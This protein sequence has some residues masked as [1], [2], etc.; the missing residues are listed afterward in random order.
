MIRSGLRGRCPN[1]SAMDVRSTGSK[2]PFCHSRRRSPSKSAFGFAMRLRRCFAVAALP[3]RPRMDANESGYRA[4]VALPADDPDRATLAGL[5]ADLARQALGKEVELDLQAVD[6]SGHWA[7]VRARLLDPGGAALSLGDTPFADAA[8]A[9]GVSDLAV[10]LFRLD[11]KST[12][13]N[14]S[15]VAIS[16]AVFCLKQ[17]SA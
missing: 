15:H 2:P 9:G 14:S 3:L 10:V 16:Y 13:L 6:R 11:R 5:A 7:V 4:P 12:R 17:T 1:S 8:A